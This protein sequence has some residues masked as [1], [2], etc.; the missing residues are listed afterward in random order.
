MVRLLASVGF[1]ALL[2]FSWATN[3][4]AQLEPLKRTYPPGPAAPLTTQAVE[5]AIAGDHA[6]ALSFAEDAIKADPKDPW[7]Y[8]NRAGA[9]AGL[10]RT[11][12]AVAAFQDSETRFSANDPW[13]RSLAIWGEANALNQAGRCKEAAPAYE[14]YAVFVEN[15]DHE[16]AALAREY[17]KHCTPR[18]PGQ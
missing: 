11:D 2:L 6:K 15:L 5:A 1:A 9:L 8:Y 18:V 14:R 3:A 12:E 4:G 13:A 17:A 10:K 16:A 7:G